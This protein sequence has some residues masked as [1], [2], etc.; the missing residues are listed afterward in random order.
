MA[1][2]ALYRSYRPTT[3]KEVIGQNH[4]IKTLIN[5]INMGR[6]G[7]AYLFCGARGTG[8]TT[9]AKILSKAVNCLNPIDGN[10]C[11]RCSACRSIDSGGT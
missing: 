10:P 7:H 1:Y 4:I 5:Q 11:N 3:F 9:C 2:V 6:I 8:K